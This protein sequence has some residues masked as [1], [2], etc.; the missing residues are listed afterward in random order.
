MSGG[1]ADG[2]GQPLLICIVPLAGDQ[3]KQYVSDA[4]GEQGEGRCEW[5]GFRVQAVGC[6]PRL[7]RPH[8]FGSHVTDRLTT[9]VHQ[10]DGGG[11]C[12][13]WVMPHPHLTNHSIHTYVSFSPNLESPPA[14]LLTPSL[15]SFAPS[16]TSPFSLPSL[17]SH[18]LV[19]LPSSLLSHLQDLRVPHFDVQCAAAHLG[20][21]H[22]LKH[23]AAACRCR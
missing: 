16:S 20:H 9:A 1:V 17:P 23:M 4:G 11:R 12:K 10:V 13:S 19:P 14:S 5:Q 7:R 2:P 21:M 6:S 18:P 3:L 15:P 8:F 22:T